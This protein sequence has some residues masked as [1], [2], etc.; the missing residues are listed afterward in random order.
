MNEPLRPSSLGEVLDRTAQL[1]RSRFLV[2]LGISVLPTGV[3]LALACVAG[4]VAAWWGAAGAHSVSSDAGYALVGLFFV[5][6]A[7]LALPILLVVTGLASAAMSHAVA[8]IHLG[9]T[10]T[11]RDAYKSVWRLGWR[12]IW[13]Y[14][15]RRLIVWVA[16]IAGWIALALLAAGATV[17]AQK[18][19]MGAS[20]DAIFGSAALLVV[21]PLAGYG[22][23]MLLRLSLAFPAAVVEQIGALRAIK[24]S[25]A[26]SQGSKG[27]ILLLY[28]LVGALGW[29]LSMAVMLLLAI[30][31]SLIP[32]IDRPPYVQTAEVAM[33][34]I[35]S[36]IAFAVQ[37][38]VE[39]IYGIA[40]VLFYF[41]Q[42]I[43]KEGYD[44][45]LLMQQAG[46]T[47]EAMP[48]LEAAPW[49]PAIPRTVPAVAVEPPRA[50]VVPRSTQ[51]ASE[52]TGDPQ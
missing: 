22:V 1:Y 8:C 17:L 20:A 9:G 33:P 42:R 40:L 41:D 6:L 28:V 7:L 44:I 13:L 16:P 3:I 11:I 52:A 38:L 37:A 29:I 51:T 49:L 32:G 47:P 19:G 23:W 24:R 35:F 27:R 36:G 43:R 25:F 2:F 31:V 14:L 45:E 21:I 18:G 30:L 50:V 26:L 39:P 4:L 34:L 10:T 46:M 12:Y 15:L 48:A 5:A